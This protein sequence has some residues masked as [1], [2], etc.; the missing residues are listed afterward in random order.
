MEETMT[1]EE[2]ERRVRTLEDIEGIKKRS[3]CEVILHAKRKG[4]KAVNSMKSTKTVVYDDG[5]FKTPAAG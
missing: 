3:F 4:E 1:I 2:L 5:F